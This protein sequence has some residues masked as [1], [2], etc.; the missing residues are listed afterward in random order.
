MV[1]SCG[2]GVFGGGLIRPNPRMALAGTGP[3]ALEEQNRYHTEDHLSL[4]HPHSGRMAVVSEEDQSSASGPRSWICVR[5][6]LV[7]TSLSRVTPH[8]NK[9]HPKMQTQA[10]GR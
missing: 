3:R 8:L 1:A 5:A 9:T 7:V 4:A 10:N 6:L 2:R